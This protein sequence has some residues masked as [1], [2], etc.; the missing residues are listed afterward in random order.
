VT[1]SELQ[2]EK[3]KH[4]GTL[5]QLKADQGTI[6]STLD[7][8][9]AERVLNGDTELLRQAV[10][11]TRYEPEELAARNVRIG[12]ARIVERVAEN[13]PELVAPYLQDLLPALE[14]PEPQ[15]KWLLL[16]TLGYCAK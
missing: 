16:V 7:N 1:G 13:R 15:T 2:L 11:L 3:T 4:H 5:E 10:A 14:T 12:A 9:L 8:A 6:S